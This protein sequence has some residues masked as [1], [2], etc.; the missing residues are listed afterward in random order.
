MRSPFL[1]LSAACLLAPPAIAAELSPAQHFFDAPRFGSVVLSPD[2]RFLALRVAAKEGREQ[3]A[4]LDTATNTAGAAAIF[5]NS[6]IGQIRWIS[7]DRLVFQMGETQLSSHPWGTGYGLYAVNR[8]GSKLSYV[9]ARGRERWEGGARAMLSGFVRLH[10]Q[11]GT[12]SSEFLYLERMQWGNWSGPYV[13]L[14][15]FNTLTGNYTTFAHPGLTASWVLDQRG[16]PRLATAI[17]NNVLTVTYLDP[18]SKTWRPFWTRRS[19]RDPH[20]TPLGFGPDGVL[21][22]SSNGDGRDT[23]A[24]YSVDLATGALGA[25]PLVSVN[26]YDLDDGLVFSDQGLLG[27]RYTAESRDTHWLD[28]TMQEIQRKIDAAL[29]GTINLVTPARRPK[30]PV[31]LVTSLSDVKPASYRLYHTQSGALTHIGDTRPQIKP[32][33][34]GR[35][36]MV[37]FPARDGLGIPAYL[38]LPPGGGAK[39]PL[40]VLVNEKPLARTTTWDWS[41]EA[42]FLASRGYAVLQVQ[43]RGV[44]GFGKHHLLAAH[45][46]WGLAMQDDLADGAKWAVRAGHADPA[47]ICIAGA[48]YGGYAALMALIKEPDLFKC[49]ISWQPVTDIASLYVDDEHDMERANATIDYAFK[50][51]VGAPLAGADHHRAISPLAQAARLTQPLLLAPGAAQGFVQ[52]DNIRFRD[53][54]K[55]TNQRVEWIP[56]D[57]MA[58]S[59]MPQLQ[60]DFWSRAEKFLGRHIGTP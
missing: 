39:L 15:R 10:D 52:R 19:T 38:T 49:G 56:Y 25:K 5:E 2:A 26:G 47:K 57:T 13:D 34:M 7:D 18:A 14:L 46:Q 21:Y 24:I 22:A 53:V 40:V 37:H 31:V 45:K 17:D 20:I 3:L 41:P 51:F 48:N 58:A 12:Q 33:Q 30:A 35:R 4:I 44:D 28:P 42:Q 27:V 16:E 23:T 29:P 55:S 50:A 43:F 60:A 6:A 59:T 1:L 54:L 32:A 9:M 36:Q 11:P 8:D